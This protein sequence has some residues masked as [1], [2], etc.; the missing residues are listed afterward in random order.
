MKILS[1]C[2]HAFF[3]VLLFLSCIAS[4][5][6]NAQTKTL[7][8]ANKWEAYSQMWNLSSVYF[9]T[10]TS[11]NLGTQLDTAVNTTPLVLTIGQYNA[12]TPTVGVN[13]DTFT[14]G[15]LSGY[16][17]GTMVVSFTG[18]KCTGTPTV[19]ASIQQSPDGII[20]SNM[21]SVSS[22]T[23]SPTSLTVPV[24]GYFSFTKTVKFY[25]VNFTGSGSSTTSWQ[26]FFYY[27]APFTFSQSGP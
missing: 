13:V 3:A 25:R 6:V 20:W 11:S 9:N 16:G 21:A 12:Y 1:I 24:T 26:A 10:A 27:L 7:P 14:L 23:F 8:Y 18:L 22:Q 5:P 4:P 2:R 17:A 19:V 15:W